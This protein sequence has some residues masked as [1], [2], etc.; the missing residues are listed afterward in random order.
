MA[1]PFVAEIRIFPSNFASKGWAFCNGQL[2]PISQNTALFSLL[3]TTYGGDGKS[4]FA[5][6]NLQGSAPMHP[7]QGPGLSLHDLGETGGS[8]TGSDTVTLLQ[9]EMPAYPHGWTASNAQATNQSPVNEMFA[10]G[11]GSINMYAPTSP[12]SITQLNPGVLPVAGG[13]QPHNNMMP[14]LT[15]NF[16]I[17]LLPEHRRAGIGTKLLRTLQNEA[18]TAGKTLTIH[19]EKF[20][21]ALRLYQRLGFRQIEDKG[22]YLFLEWK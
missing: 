7:G 14:Y 4:N 18:R 17:A 12:A 6:P 13:N 8:D 1:N 9:S 20:N 15:L 19:V 22:V 16:I 21:P 2:L 11:V 3:G 10:G 5:L